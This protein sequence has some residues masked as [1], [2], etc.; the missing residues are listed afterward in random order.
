MNI[1]NLDITS[2]SLIELLKILLKI[3]ELLAN[4]GNNDFQMGNA[5]KN[6]YSVKYGENTALFKHDLYEKTINFLRNN[7]KEEDLLRISEKIKWEKQETMKEEPPK[8]TQSRS[9][10]LR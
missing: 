5:V 9:H 4:T 1:F 7:F 2:I 3:F 6:E 10:A 8:Q